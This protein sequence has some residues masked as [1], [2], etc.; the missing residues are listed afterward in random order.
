MKMF[1]EKY[2]ASGVSGG[3]GSE[4]SPWS[5]TEMVSAY[6]LGDRINVKSGDYTIDSTLTMAIAGTSEIMIPVRGYNT[7]IGDLD[8]CQRDSSGTL[9]TTNFP[10]LT[11][12][13]NL[14]LAS[15][16]TLSNFVIDAD[17]SGDLLGASSADGCQYI[18]SKITNVSDSSVSATIRGDDNTG[19]INCDFYPSSTNFGSVIRADYYGLVYG[20]RFVIT[21]TAATSIINVGNPVFVG[22]VVFGNGQLLMPISNTVIGA[23]IILLNTIY[24]CGKS[25]TLPANAVTNIP[26]IINNHIT[27]SDQIIENLYSDTA[28]NV[29]IEINNRYRDI[30]NAN[31]GIGDG[32]SVGEIDTDTGGAETDFEDIDS[33]NAT[34]LDDAVGV[35]AGVGIGSWNIGASQNARVSSESGSGLTTEQATWLEAI[36]TRV[37]LSLPEAAPGTAE[38][39]VQ[40]QDLPSESDQAQ[41]TSEYIDA[42]ATFVSNITS[43][44]AT[45]DRLDALIEDSD[46][47][48][49]T[50]KAL[51]T[52]PSGTVSATDVNIVSVA[53]TEVTSVDDFKADVS[54]L[55]LESTKFDPTVDEV[56]TG[57]TWKSAF[58]RLLSVDTGKTTN[59]GK[60]F[61]SICGT[62]IRLVYSTLTDYTRTIDSEDLTDV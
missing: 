28:N 23:P 57:Y 59:G 60:S 30:V 33:Y 25:I 8:E 10:V 58:R 18:N 49:F 6:A 5:L 45:T 55:A 15:K 40:N 35:D 16:I 43:V 31:V 11:M 17:Y 20:N 26:Y 22:N 51:E 56:E 7:T 36:N 24:N 3:D 19:V 4:A 21:G 38:G 41:T 13:A 2:V 27:D 46:G 37:I 62:K 32:I 54:L 53:G 61:W 42:N 14:V 39:L 48:R 44:K 1:N 29:V 9:I 47:D 50:E 12:T 34:L 52:A